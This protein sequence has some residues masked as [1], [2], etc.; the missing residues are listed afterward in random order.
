[1]NISISNINYSVRKQSIS[2][3]YLSI[4][5]VYLLISVKTNRFKS[6]ALW[7]AALWSQC[8]FCFHHGISR[9]QNSAWHLA[10]AHWYF[11]YPIEVKGT[12]RSIR[13]S[14]ILA[15][16]KELRKDSQGG[17]S[18]IC[19]IT[20]PLHIST[21]ENKFLTDVLFCQP[22]ILNYG[23]GH[24]LSYL[25]QEGRRSRKRSWKNC[26]Q[27][28]EERGTG[29]QWDHSEE[30]TDDTVSSKKGV[31]GAWTIS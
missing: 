18:W 27:L 25:R 5:S 6:L 4:F 8:P 14:N 31:L 2:K 7:R 26:W 20:K 3:C 28:C 30:D 10:D 23:Q 19:I 11:F 24:K 22:H 16:V 12:F 13:K 15:D 1:M 21:L 9:A 17:K 29:S